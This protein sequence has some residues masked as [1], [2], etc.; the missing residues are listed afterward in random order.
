MACKEIESPK[1]KVLSRKFLAA[2]LRKAFFEDWSSI[3]HQA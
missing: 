3:V 2:K 1:Y